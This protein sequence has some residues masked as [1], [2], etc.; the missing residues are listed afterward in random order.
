M[1]PTITGSSDTSTA[2]R[3]VDRVRDRAA[4]QLSAQKG[5]ATDSLDNLAQAARRSTQALRDS[6][7][8][9]VAQYV[10]RAADHIE[11]FSTRLREQD[12]SDVVQ[13][14]QQFA[15]RQPA[16]FIG[17]TFALGMVAVRF[18][19]SSARNSAYGGQRRLGV[20]PYEVAATSRYEP[21]VTADIAAETTSR[22]ESGGL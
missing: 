22:Y 21:S 3:V 9:A 1:E 10:E 7:Q 11:R 12:A 18:L 13:H 2:Q 20:N 15:R 17:A 6:Q 16:L 8:D 5:R 4:S 19:K 14:V